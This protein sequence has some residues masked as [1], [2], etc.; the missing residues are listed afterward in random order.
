MIDVCSEIDVRLVSKSYNKTISQKG[1]AA[2][3]DIMLLIK[4]LYSPF[5]YLVLLQSYDENFLQRIYF[6]ATRAMLRNR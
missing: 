4:N 6:V 1:T 2:I 5:A 3:I